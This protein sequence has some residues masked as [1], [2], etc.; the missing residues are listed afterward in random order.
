MPS[1]FNLFCFY[2]MRSYDCFRPQYMYPPKNINRNNSAINLNKFFHYMEKIR[3]TNIWRIFDVVAII[4]LNI[5]IASHHF[6]LNLIDICSIWL[7]RFVIPINWIE[8]DW[9]GLH[10]KCVLCLVFIIILGNLIAM[11]IL[12]IYFCAEK[13]DI[14]F[15]FDETT[16]I[17]VSMDMEWRN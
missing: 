12:N 11:K 9:C 13:H 10:W 3:F 4:W 8:W 16:A 2:W 1:Y 7:L 15:G 6:R 5:A 17:V 14:Y